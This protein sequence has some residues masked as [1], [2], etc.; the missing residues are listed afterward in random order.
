MKAHGCAAVGFTSPRVW[1]NATGNVQLLGGN[2]AAFRVL[3]RAHPG[4]S[5]VEVVTASCAVTHNPGAPGFEMEQNFS[6]SGCL[7]RT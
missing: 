7:T 5:M 2:D 3:S 4:C 6:L 1:R